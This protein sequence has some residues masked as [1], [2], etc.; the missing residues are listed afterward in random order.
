[1][2]R[3]EIIQGLRDIDTCQI[4]ESEVLDEAIKALEQE[5]TTKNNL[6]VDCI[7]RADAIKG[8]GE[9]PYVW[10]DSDFEIQQ[11]ADWK[12]HK[13]MLE[14]LPSVTPQEPM[15]IPIAEVKFDED[16]LK[17]LANRAVLTV[18][19]QEPILDKIRAEIKALPV[20]FTC[21]HEMQKWALEI[22]DKYKAESEEVI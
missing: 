15:S 9:Q 10:T 18:T 1:M 5:P 6:G 8:L 3:E 4:W 16:K 17:E 11:L 13:E 7:S 20:T 19:P 12:T 14:N 2:T 21:A 22:I